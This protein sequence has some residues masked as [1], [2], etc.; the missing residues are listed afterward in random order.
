[1]KIT[2]KEVE[3][4][5]KLA[6]LELSDQAKD[7]FTDQLSNILTYVEQLNELDTKDVPPT[8]HV[9]DMSNVMRDDVPQESLSQERALAN[10][11]DKAAGHYRVPK[12]IE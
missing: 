4:V 8:S 3:H 1:M 12:I 9:L 11:P 7:V 10:A 6:R 5:A 2:K